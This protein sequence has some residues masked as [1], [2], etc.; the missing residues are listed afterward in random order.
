MSRRLR[1]AFLFVLGL[2]VIAST[3]VQGQQS[4]VTA[5]DQIAVAAPLLGRRSPRAI[6]GQPLPTP[7]VGGSPLKSRSLHQK[8]LRIPPSQPET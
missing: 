2:V 8:A 7:C 6:A 4:V 3:G 1:H 5:S